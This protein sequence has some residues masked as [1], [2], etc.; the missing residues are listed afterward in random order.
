MK[1][2]VASENFILYL[3]SFIENRF[4]SHAIY[5]IMVSSSSTPPS[6]FPFFLPSGA[7]LFLSLDRKQTAKGY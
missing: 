5:L 7:S 1:K 6:S 2:L 3:F 4:F